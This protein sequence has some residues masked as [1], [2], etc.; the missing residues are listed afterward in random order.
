MEE[1]RA[2]ESDVVIDMPDELLEDSA[3]NSDRQGFIAFKKDV[4]HSNDVR[5]RT[6][7]VVRNGGCG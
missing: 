4:Q 6:L 5:G 2:A 1:T 3:S 7:D